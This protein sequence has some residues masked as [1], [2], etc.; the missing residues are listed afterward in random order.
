MSIWQSS[1]CGCNMIAKVPAN[2]WRLRM[3]LLQ[4][5]GNQQTLA[6]RQAIAADQLLLSPSTTY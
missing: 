1:I 6:L 2:Y 3:K 4:Y 5:Y